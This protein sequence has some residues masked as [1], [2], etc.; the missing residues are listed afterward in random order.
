MKHHLIRLLFLGISFNCSAQIACSSLEPG[1]LDLVIGDSLRF[2]KSDSS[3]N[4][5]SIGF[6]WTVIPYV[7]QNDS[8]TG[9]GYTS[10]GEFYSFEGCSEI[11]K[12]GQFEL[13]TQDILKDYSNL[14]RIRSK[15]WL[16]FVPVIPGYK[17]IFLGVQEDIGVLHV[18][19]DNDSYSLFIRE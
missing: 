19:Y 6:T 13:S 1:V 7:F 17:Y 15:C 16:F 8:I 14:I 18:Y 3:R 11:L 5:S 12:Q 2:E 10:N 4:S 9:I